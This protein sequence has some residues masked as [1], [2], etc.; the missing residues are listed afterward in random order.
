MRTIESRLSVALRLTVT[1]RCG[2]AIDGASAL[3]ASRRTTWRTSFIQEWSAFTVARGAHL[4]DGPASTFTGLS[5]SPPALAEW[6]L[7]PQPEHEFQPGGGHV[8]RLDIPSPVPIPLADGELELSW[9]GGSSFGHLDVSIELQPRFFFQSGD[10]VRLDDFLRR[11]GDPLEYFLG[12]VLGEPVLTREVHFAVGE[13]TDL[14]NFRH[15]SL[16]LWRGS[17]EVGPPTR[18]SHYWEH[19]L[20]FGERRESIGEL[21]ARWIDMCERFRSAVSEFF[22]ISISPHMYGEEQFARTVRALEVWS[23]LSH[24]D[25]PLSGDD[26]AELKSRLRSTCTAEE[27]EFLRVRIEFANELSLKQ[28]LDRL[29]DLSPEPLRGL[30]LAYPKFTRRVVDARNTL[31]HRGSLSS[32]VFDHTE[33]YWAQ[34][35]LEALFVV[36]LLSEVG[37][38]GDSG[39]LL[40]RTSLWRSLI[41]EFNVL[42]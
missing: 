33:M 9:S 3:E 12:L 17:S 5:F 38:E 32:N 27:W 11:I 13:P 30:L 29:V 22:S 41:S 10:G 23:R 15:G 40:T 25:K 1:S 8:V 6:V 16:V 42:Q 4:P 20:A 26:F 18:A 28:R 31:T 37:L 19:L 2:T 36:T 35:S 24:D 39:R 34:R 21:L 14:E 7:E